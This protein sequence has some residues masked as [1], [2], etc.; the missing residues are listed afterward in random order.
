MLTDDELLIW[1]ERKRQGFSLQRIA[2]I[3]EGEDTPCSTTFRVLSPLGQPVSCARRDP[4][5]AI[6]ECIHTH[7]SPQEVDR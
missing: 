6:R 1:G 7:E 2:H 4:S 5:A 3:K